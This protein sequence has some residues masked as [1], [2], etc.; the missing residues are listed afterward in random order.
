MSILKLAIFNVLPVY[1]ICI[2]INSIKIETYIKSHLYGVPQSENIQLHSSIRFSR[3]SPSSL[4]IYGIRY[5]VIQLV[6]FTSIFKR[7]GVLKFG[8]FCRDLYKTIPT[9]ISLGST[10]QHSFLNIYL[11]IKSLL[12]KKE[13]S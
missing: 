1:C 7:L 2:N 13:I 4:L 12:C 10:T 11:T 6:K 9:L 5:I 3:V 8:Y